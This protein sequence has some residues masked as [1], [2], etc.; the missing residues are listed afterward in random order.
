MSDD[1]TYGRPKS[2]DIFTIDFDYLQAM[3]HQS[4]PDIIALKV[5]WRV[6]SDSDV[7][8]VNQELDV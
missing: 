4:L 6:T 2:I 5:L 7:V 8:V 1:V 3:S